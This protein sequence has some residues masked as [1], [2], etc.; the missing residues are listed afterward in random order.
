MIQFSL[1]IFNNKG[2]AEEKN[3]IVRTM[4]S[5]FPCL[6]FHMTTHV[7]DYTVRIVQVNTFEQSQ[8]S[9]ISN[10]CVV[11]KELWLSS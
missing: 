6:Y 10:K 8:S 2:N 9:D 7:I 3:C 11:V 5:E 4:I 1:P